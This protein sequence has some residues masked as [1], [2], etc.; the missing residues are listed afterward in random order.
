MKGAGHEVVVLH[1]ECPVTK[2]MQQ[3]RL[4]SMGE[5]WRLKLKMSTEKTFKKRFLIKTCMSL[6]QNE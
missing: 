6:K 4:A 1:F 5:K 2:Q 3:D